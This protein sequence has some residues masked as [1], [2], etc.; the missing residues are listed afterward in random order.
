MRQ[1]DLHERYLR[2][3]WPRQLGNLASTLARLGARVGDP[4]YDQITSDLLREGALFMEWSAPHVPSHLVGNL[5]TMQRELCLWRRIWPVEAA[6]P[7][8]AFRA[9]TMSNQVLEWSGLVP[10]TERHSSG[11]EDR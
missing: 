11:T 8:L 3:E 2:D 4:R 5:A 9:Q 10:Q 1:Q 7:L 6:R